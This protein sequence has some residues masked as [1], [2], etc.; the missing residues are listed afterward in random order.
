[1]V[2][3]LEILLLVLVLVAVLGA[4]TL[5]QTVRPFIVNA[6]VGL[7]VLFVVQALFN[8][9]IAV[10]PVAIAI[11]A[12]GGVPGAVLVLLL[13]MFGVGFVP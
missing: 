8:L 1:M 12:L 13:S 9:S 3:G 10:T 11:V 4:S 7:L 2:T 6:A 5:I